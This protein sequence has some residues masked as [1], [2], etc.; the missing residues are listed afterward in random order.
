MHACG[1]DGHTAVGLT[2][3]RI[4]QMHLK[5]LKGTVKL[6]FQPAEEGLGGAERMVAE[7][8]LLDPKPDITLALHLWNERPV[9]WIGISGGPTMAA[10]EIF[11]IKL[12]GKG[13][14]GAVPDLTVDPIVAASSIVTGLQSIVS[15]NVSPL[16]TAVVSVCSIHAGE[17]FNVIP[18][19]AELSGTIRTF[20]PEV[21][22]VVL[23]RFD[24]LVRGIAQSNGCSVEIELKSLT[25][26]VINNPQ[27]AA[28]VM[29]SAFSIFPEKEI[30]QDFR[31][32]GS[33]DMA[34]MMQEIPGCY[35]FIGSANP[36]M[37]LNFPHHHPRF[38]IDEESLPIA[39]AVMA[40]S[41]LDILKSKDAI[42]SSEIS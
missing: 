14:H 1:H 9:G 21:R 13:G 41:I 30:H 7:G 16:K 19:Y 24:N 15:R 35:F 34:F 10:A 27:I 22:D 39:A 6:V 4:L 29:N 17:A 32:M 31:T 42:H 18:S 26:A 25:P 37:G 20:E 40:G 23:G 11:K 33:E 2:V 38:D 12:T 8:V 28:D 5:E 3:A 36:Q